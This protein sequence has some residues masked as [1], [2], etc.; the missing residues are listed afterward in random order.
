[1]CVWNALI[2]LCVTPVV[3]GSLV[4]CVYEYGEVFAAT[5][6]GVREEVCECFERPPTVAV[7]QGGSLKVEKRSWLL[8]RRGEGTYSCVLR[9][10]S[11]SVCQ[12][13]CVC[14]YRKAFA[15]PTM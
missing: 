1:M 7:R 2:W 15:T 6:A 3:R 4:G 10:S 12:G 13:V 11:V 14:G 9:L 8:S 5:F